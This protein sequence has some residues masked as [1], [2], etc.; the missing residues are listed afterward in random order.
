MKQARRNFLVTSVGA[1]AAWMALGMLRP[2]GANAAQLDAATSGANNLA[3]AYQALGVGQM[4]ES[5]DIYINAPEIAESGVIVPVEVTSK[6]G[7]T[8]M[9]A[10]LV[11]KNPHPLTAQFAIATGTQGYVN[12]RMK[13]SSSSPVHIVVQ[14]GGKYYHTMKL[15]KL[16]EGGCG[17]GGGSQ[18]VDKGFVVEPVRV[19]TV[20]EA[21]LCSVKLVLN[22]PMENGLRRDVKTGQIVPAHYIQQ[23]SATLN[24]R[25]VMNAQWSQSIAKN[26][27][28]GFKVKGARSGDRI[29]VAWV[30]NQGNKNTTDAVVS[31]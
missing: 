14:A 5:K 4:I 1:G 7:G 28:L 12:T 29:S 24:G 17:G 3:L 9:I 10:I 11:E 2:I 25:M 16:T 6:L 22:H 23:V 15:V 19:R 31:A 20:M 30:D 21:D 18:V 26:P 27:F 8:S 13:M